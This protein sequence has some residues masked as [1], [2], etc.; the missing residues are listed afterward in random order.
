MVNQL[1]MATLTSY[2]ATRDQHVITLIL[3]KIDV[4]NPHCQVILL[5]PDIK[6]SE[7]FLEVK[8]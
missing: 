1:E 5:A 8:F 4:S 7:Q 3:E 2:L 6:L